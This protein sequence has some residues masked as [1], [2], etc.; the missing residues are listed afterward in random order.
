MNSN[1]IAIFCL[2]SVVLIMYLAKY[3]TEILTYIILIWFTF[4]VSVFV[5][6]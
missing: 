6:S 4:N 1:L 3:E 5:C 2:N